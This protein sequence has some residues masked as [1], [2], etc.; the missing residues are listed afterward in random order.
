[1]KKIIKNDAKWRNMLNLYKFC[2]SHHPCGENLL[3]KNIRCG[4]RD[5]LLNPNIKN[6]VMVFTKKRRGMNQM[7]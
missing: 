2:H 5:N 1:M 3:A 6:P 7:F 4:I